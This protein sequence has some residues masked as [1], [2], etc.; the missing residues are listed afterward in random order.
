MK[1]TI[2][3]LIAM[4]VLASCSSSSWVRKDM[5][6]RAGV[7]QYNSDGADFIV[8]SKRQGALDKITLFCKG[9]YEILAEAGRVEKAGTYTTGSSNTNSSA[10]ATGAY[11]QSTNFYGYGT[12]TNGTAN[13]NAQ[14]KSTTNASTTS[15]ALKSRTTFIQF[16]CNKQIPTAV[17]SIVSAG[18]SVANNNH[19][20]W[21]EKDDNQKIGTIG[22]KV[23][24][25]LKISNELESRT[26]QMVKDFC[27]ADFKVTN[28]SIVKISMDES[29]K[30]ISFNCNE[31]QVPLAPKS[32]VVAK[33]K[34]ADSRY[35]ELYKRLQYLEWQIKQKDNVN[36]EGKNSGPFVSFS[37]GISHFSPDNLEKERRDFYT[38][39]NNTH[40]SGFIFGTLFEFEIGNRFNFGNGA[41][42][43][44]SLGKQIFNSETVSGSGTD[45]SD[46]KVDLE[47]SMEI[48]AIFLRATYLMTNPVD[49]KMTFGPGVTIG[50]IS[51]ALYRIELSHDSESLDFEAKGKGHMLELFGKA[52][53]E[54]SDTFVTSASAGVKYTKIKD[55][56]L[57]IGSY[58]DH[59]SS[60][61]TSDTD[62]FMRFSLT[63][64]L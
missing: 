34:E 29:V 33:N 15:F 63:M 30:S 49:V 23:S 60:I 36:P 18:P 41:S 28:N 35:K 21:I 42:L 16:K 25:D 64:N 57:G 47:E 51:E 24:T 58:T 11:S 62:A 38:E 1:N 61:N 8:E 50:Y 48:D 5:V 56:K 19:I 46:Q 54:V 20:K 13:V 31:T 27:K 4:L 22:Y 14:S 17:Q 6:N 9:P 52:G 3:I 45:S 37:M 32:P 2:P 26:N 43:E 53:Y 59:S 39:L 10:S 7:I 40:W 55:M 12:T 44:V